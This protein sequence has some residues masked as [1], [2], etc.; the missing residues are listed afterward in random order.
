MMR[1]EQ[2]EREHNLSPR[3]VGDYAL[4]RQK[5]KDNPAALSECDLLTLQFFGSDHEMRQ[6]KAARDGTTPPSAPVT[7]P[8]PRTFDDASLRR[9]FTVLK[10]FV[11]SLMP[12][13]RKHDDALSRLEQLEAKVRALEDHQRDRPGLKYCGT[14]E[15]GVVYQI[16]DCV[17]RQG[18]IWISRHAHNKAVPGTDGGTLGWQLAVKA[19]RDGKD[20]R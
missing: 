1:L 2:Y 11:E 5:V 17:T 12:W 3:T 14:H 20:L 8:P 13:M 7:E 16:G 10:N 19:G 9:K 4:V 6:A 18:G 15:A